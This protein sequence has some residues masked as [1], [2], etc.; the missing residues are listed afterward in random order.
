MISFP[1]YSLLR[2]PSRMVKFRGI[3]VSLISQHDVRKFPEYDPPI[4]ADP[5]WI[6][7]PVPRIEKDSIASC[8]VPYYPGSQVCID[9]SIDN[10]HPPSAQY[11]FKLLGNGKVFTSWDCT[12]KHQYQGRTTYALKY[13]CFHPQTGQQIVERQAFRFSTEPSGCPGP[14]DNCI[15]VRVYRIEHRIRLSLGEA[16]IQ[17][18]HSYARHSTDHHSFRCVPLLRNLSCP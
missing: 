17:G 8:Y 1:I 12:A 3:N 10:P 18:Y 9:Y 6:D 13:L 5:F 7:G 2:P 14:F 16:D 4:S 11:F 15:E